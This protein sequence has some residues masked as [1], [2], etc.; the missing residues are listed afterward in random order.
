MAWEEVK[1]IEMLLILKVSDEWP[2]ADLNYDSLVYRDGD[3]IF[4]I[5]TKSKTRENGLVEKLISFN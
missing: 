1:I 5:S 3:L 4:F 2:N